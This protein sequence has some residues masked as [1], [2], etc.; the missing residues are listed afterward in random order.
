[1]NQASSWGT[2]VEMLTLAHML[3]TPVFSYNPVDGDWHRHSPADVDRE[4]HD[5][6]T[7]MAMYIRHPPGHFDVVRAV[8]N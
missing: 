6:L 2:E 5:S 1:M 8:I 3:Q 7:Q 4:L